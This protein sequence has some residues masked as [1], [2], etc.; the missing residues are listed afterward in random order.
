MSILR[1]LRLAPG[2]GSSAAPRRA[3]S[4]RGMDRREHW[5]DVYRSRPDSALSWHQ[6][7][8]AVSLAIIDGL[9]PAPRVAID[10][11]GGQ[12]TLAGA[13][14]ERGLERVVVIDVAAAALERGRARL[15]EAAGAV[16][17][18]VGDVTGPEVELP[19]VDLWHDRAVFHFLTGEAERR[20]YLERAAASVRRGGWLVVAT[21]GPDAPPQCSGLPVRRY[22]AAALAEAF[23]PAFDLVS[24]RG[25]EHRTPWG[26]AQ[27]FVYAVLRRSDASRPASGPAL[28]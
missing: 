11:G 14:V 10:V 12:S 27:P 25:E 13:L 9:T 24:S 6:D 4:I 7:E 18:I 23:A 2:G 1:D 8:P 17:W 15:G 28:P 3:G 5:N 22:D 16:E 19:E 26:R 20:R 21:F